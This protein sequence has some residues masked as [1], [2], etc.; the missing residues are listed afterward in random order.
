MINIHSII[1][2]KNI[3]FFEIQTNIG[4]GETEQNSI[5]ISLKKKVI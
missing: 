1:V 5:F 4:L 2:E 3:L